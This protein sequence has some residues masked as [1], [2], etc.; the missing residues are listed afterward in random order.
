MLRG[1]GHDATIP[2]EEGSPSV[3]TTAIV[4]AWL[5]LAAGGV[6]AAPGNNAARAEVSGNS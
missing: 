3:Q 6:I 1:R 5:A 4:A 2:V